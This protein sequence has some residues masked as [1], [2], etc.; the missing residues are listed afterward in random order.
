MERGFGEKSVFKLVVCFFGL[1]NVLID[2]YDCIG[3]YYVVV[4]N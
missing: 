2:D 4:V 3:N 1:E